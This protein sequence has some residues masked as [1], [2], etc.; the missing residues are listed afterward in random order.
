[1]ASSYLVASDHTIV[2]L[3]GFEGADPAPS[4]DQLAGWVEQ[5]RV[6][7]VVSSSTPPSSKLDTTKPSAIMATL[8]G[9]AEA[10]R[11]TWVQGHCKSV[12]GLGDPVQALFDCDPDSR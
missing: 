12:S 2:A 6:R 9:S 11:T 8:G 3:G 10:A 7:Y 1:M 5:G 4:A